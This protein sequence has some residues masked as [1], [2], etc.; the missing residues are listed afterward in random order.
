MP[1]LICKAL[2]V[3]HHFILLACS[4]GQHEN[5]VLLLL[6][7]GADVNSH[8]KHS[9]HVARNGGHDAIVALLGNTQTIQP[10]LRLSRAS[11]TAW[12]ASTSEDSSEDMPVT[13][14]RGSN[15]DNAQTRNCLD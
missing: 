12:I 14:N 9:L 7:H 11:Q 8:S 10:L 1:A 6:E 5:V 3:K 13:K 2:L 15:R 4:Y